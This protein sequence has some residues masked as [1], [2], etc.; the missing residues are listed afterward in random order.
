VNLLREIVGALL[1]LGV[2][3]VVHALATVLAFRVG[4]QHVTGRSR[5]ARD[6]VRVRRLV[7]VVAV[8]FVAH[9]FEAAGWGAWFLARGFFPDFEHALH[10]S[11]GAYTTA[12]T[13]GLGLPAGWRLLGSLESVAGML[14]FG[15]STGIIA[16]IVLRLVEAEE[17]PHGRA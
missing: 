14:M 7:L 16:T 2:T 9:L 17:A 10:F 4:R 15:W 12:G 13:S 3:G 6:A 5:R 11:L 8:F 1:L